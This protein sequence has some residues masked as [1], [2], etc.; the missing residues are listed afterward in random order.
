MDRRFSSIAAFEKSAKRRIP[1]FAADYLFGGIGAESCVLRNTEGFNRVLL[2]SEHLCSADHPVCHTNLLGH[3]Y[4]AP[5]GVAPIGLGGLI[6]PRAAELMATAAKNHNLP[7]LLSTFATTD[8]ETARAAGGDSTWF[9]LYPMI[10][11]DMEDAVL[12]RA[13]KSGYEVLVVTVDIPTITRR[14]RD[15]RN[16]LS[17]PPRFE[18]STLLQIMARPGW[19]LQTLVDGI[20]RFETMMPYVPKELSNEEQIKF[21]AGA[22]NAHVTP[23][24][25]ARL[26]SRWK[27]WLVIKG[28]LDT[29]DA[30]LCVDS[31]ADAIVVSNHGGRQLDAA[32]HALDMLPMIREVVG[33]DLPLIV[34]GGIRSGLDVARAIACGADF[35]LLG[36]AFICATAAAGQAGCEHAMTFLKEEL[37][38]SMVQVGCEQ[39]SDLPAH[40]LD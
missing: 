9:Q 21:L 6:W 39:L 38:H 16:G 1:R 7:F 36:R 31:G 4:D 25:L 12:E 19:A 22:I 10:D 2:R 34:D 29:A 35:T 27:G 32:P 3:R 37:R 17:V 5:F 40:L 23:E 26:R 14:E 30:R 11:T 24:K 13:E 18:L 33:P 15:A 20:P 28:V 8:I